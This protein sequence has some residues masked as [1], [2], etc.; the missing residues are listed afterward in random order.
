MAKK[1]PYQSRNFADYRTDLV[2]FVK[3]YYPDILQDFNDSSIGALFLDLNAAIGDN[4]S[5][6][7]DRMFNEVF[8]DYAKERKSILAM[9]RTM[10]LNIPGKRPSICVVDFSA[11]LPVAGDT[12]DIEY[13]P[14]IRKGSQVQG[15]GK[16]FETTDDIDFSSPFA[17]GGVPNRTVVPNFD[18]NSNIVSYTVTK[19]EIVLNGITKIFKRTVTASDVRPF[20]EVILPDTDVLEVTSVITLDGTSFSTTPN[21]SQFLNPNNRW[22]EVEALAQ[23]EIFIE[24]KNRI[25]DN[26]SILP[27]KF[28]PIDRKFITEYTDLGFKKVI[29]GG[30][31]EDVSSITDFNLQDGFT[32]RIGDFINNLSLGSTLPANNTLFI[33][34]RVGGGSTSNIGSNVLTSLGVADIFVNGSNS[35]TNQ[36][37]RNSITVNNPFPALGGRDEP[38]VEEIKYL[39]KYN[40][41]AQN[42]AVT[43]K[44]YQVMISKMPPQFGVPFRTGVVEEQNK[45]KVYTL[46]LDDSGKL[47]NTS[48]QTLKENIAEYLADFRMLNDYV[49]VTDGRIINLGFEADL[50]IDKQFPKSQIISEVIGVISDYMD[51]NKWDMGENVYLAQMIEQINNVGGVLNVTDLRVFNKVGGGKYSI[52]EIAQPYVDDAT[53]QVDLLGENIIFGEP[54][55]LYEIKYPTSDIAIRVK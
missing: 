9:A 2:N 19:R 17:A 39:T 27:G 33:Q 30:G 7:T 23:G 32:K 54:N 13:A 12:F 1:I 18:G 10:G 28:V 26:G 16:V 31:S 55:S 22:Y 52:N 48:T 46:G 8:I 49:E 44:D 51:I 25:S 53:R 29:F 43:L 41:S 6:H 42:R 34:Y 14:I 37:V 4:L 47:T 38:S 40:N 15:A 20:F 3:Q 50:Y 21:A 45:V 35:T 24:D 36:S 11:T 5:Y